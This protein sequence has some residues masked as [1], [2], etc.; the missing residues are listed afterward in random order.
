M[1]IKRLVIAATVLV[2]LGIVN[3]Q[4]DDRIYTA[5]TDLSQLATG[6][7]VIIAIQ[8]GA[9]TSKW[10]AMNV[11]TSNNLQGTYSDLENKVVSN[12]VTNP[13]KEITWYVTKNSGTPTT[14]TFQNTVSSTY[15]IA[16]NTGNTSA[17]TTLTSTTLSS[18]TGATN[19]LYISHLNGIYFKIQAD[20]DEGRWMC[21]NNTTPSKMASYTYSSNNMKAQVTNGLAIC[22]YAYEVSI[23]KK[24]P[25]CAKNVTISKGSETN[26]SLLL[27]KTSVPTCSETNSDREVTITVTANTGYELTSSARLTFT[28]T[29]ATASE[30]YVSGPTGS[31]PYTFVYRFAQN[32]TGA[33]TFGVTATAKSCSVTF[34]KNDG[35]GGSDGTTAT[36]D[37]A[38]TAITPPTRV[39]YTFAGYWDAETDNNGSGTQYYKADGTSNKNWDKDTKDETTLYAK[40]TINSYTLAIASVG[41]VEISSTTPEL[42]ETESTSQTYNTTVTLSHGDVGSSKEWCGW[43]V[44]KTGDASTTVTVTDNQFTMPAYNVTVSANLCGD[45]RFSCGELTL[46]VKPATAGTPIFI[47]STANKTVRSQDTIQITGNGLTPS[48][49]LTFPGLPSK[50]AIKKANGTE[51]ATDGSGEIDEN[52]FIFYRPDAEDT[53]DGLDKLIG[54]TASVGGAKPKIDT[55][56]HDIIGRHLP[57]DFVIAVKRNNKWLALPATM[58]ELT[59]PSPAEIS[60]D[61]IDNPSIAYTATSNIY[62]MYPQVS[63]TISGVSGKL[64]TDGQTVKLGMKNNSN[65]PL[66]GAATGTSTIKGDGTATVTN[67]IGSQYWWTFTQTASSITNAKDAQYSVKCSNNTAPFVLKENAGNPQWGFFTTGSVGAIRIIPASSAVYAEA[68]IVEWGKNGAVIEVDATAISATKAKAILGEDES[69]IVDINQTLTCGGNNGAT[70][71]NYTID[72]GSDIDFS[73][74]SSYGAMLVIEWYN[75]SS[76][77]VG[78]SNITVPKI[79]A[80]DI[81]INKTNY[82]KKTDW[83]IEVHVL[84]GDTLKVNADYTPNADVTIKE[85]NIYPGA[86][87]IVTGGT[88]KPTTLVLRNGWKCIGGKDYDVARLYIGGS[89]SMSKPTN[90]YMDWYIDF[91]HYYPI[92]VPWE[93][94]LGSNDGSK[95]K[96]LNTNSAAIIGDGSGTSV[97]LRYYDGK[98]R[99]ENGQTGVGNSAN[100][101]LYGGAGNRAIPATLQPG[102]GYAMT[103]KRPTGKA[104][105]IIR[106]P[107]TIPSADWTTSGEQGEVSPTHKDTVYVSAWGAGQDIPTYTKGWNFIANPY[108]STY[109]GTIEYA[110]GTKVNHVNIP[111]VDFK[112]FG[113]YATATTKLAPASA[114]LIQAPETGAV[115]FG[116]AKRA[117]SAPSYRNQATE[118]IP[119]QQAYIL[120]SQGAKE[121]MMGIFV[122]KKYTADYDLNGDLEKLLSDGNTLRA[123]MNYINM[124]L[125]YVAVNEE[126]AKEWLPVSVRIPE[127]GEYT[128]RMHEAS[129]ADELVGV[130][131]TD[132]LTG[133][134]TNL[135]YDS[136]TFTAEAGTNTERFAINAI[137]GERKVP[138]SMDVTGGDVNGN[139]PVKF[140]W[141][142]KVY[143]LHNNVIY[144]STGKRVNVINK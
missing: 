98:S 57:A 121:D 3:M 50:F 9:T 59:N 105:S 48:T 90:T 71:Y 6:D 144:D 86:T 108:M 28:Q 14:Y 17:Y 49:T 106:M 27:G 7:S 36:Y 80:S 96:Y 140:I 138:T 31:N 100:W 77:L 104:F 88:L 119:E 65:K 33:G 102:K 117:A 79:V 89:A 131:L 37:A 103:A 95:L 132:Y 101:K 92:A 134:T 85:L 112:E 137:V 116:T 35:T 54:I 143:I 66:F 109:K 18:T 110:S 19:T 64:Y 99:A 76:V 114:F 81:T 141:H 5:I 43:N 44:Y 61:N 12:D 26:A 113:Q 11:N 20:D 30:A 63:T 25:P 15:Y 118:V 72:F 91:D 122:S 46:T 136:Y 40:W 87:V 62:N 68:E 124:N 130:Y 70:K 139:E 93:V 135:M 115:T 42:A 73:A 41:D 78:V 56:R 22:Q 97:R 107:L 55:L 24:Q 67:N 1:L 45:Y 94:D 133:V 32:N 129:I 142:D 127:A 82:P 111:D 53:S 84:P 83:D 29:T 8:D 16:M 51:L 123:W 128:F 125:A 13:R 34:D 10:W 2:Q 60:V 4:A 23:F 38:M 69:S 58:N 39:G 21:A 75:S 120:L 52:A 126:L 47:T 74:S